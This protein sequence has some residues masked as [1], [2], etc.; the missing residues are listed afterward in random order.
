MN[1]LNP[2]G[3][4]GLFSLPIIV[5]LHL[6]RDRSRQVTVSNL[7]MWEFLDVQ[8]AGQRPRKLPRSWILYIDLL[9][10]LLLSLA[11]ARPEMDFLPLIEEK[12]HVIILLDDSTSMLAT[13]EIPTRFEAAKQRTFQE[14]NNLNEGDVISVITFGGE[15]NIVGDNRDMSVGDLA[16]RINSLHAGSEG[17]YLQDAVELAEFLKHPTLPSHILVFTDG[18][19]EES[20]IGGEILIE[21]FG[22]PV[23]NQALL[24]LDVVQVSQFKT[25]VFVRVVNF[26]EEFTTRE[27]VLIVDGKEIQNEVIGLEPLG[28]LTKT[29]SLAGTPENVEINLVGR[30][31]LLED[32]SAYFVIHQGNAVQVALVAEEPFPLDKALNASP[33]VELEIFTPEE[34]HPGLFYDLIVFRGYL[35]QVWP[36]GLVLVVDPP[37]S[38]TLLEVT[39]IIEVGENVVQEDVTALA[40]V[41]LDTVRWGGAWLV[42]N[43]KNYRKL[44][45][46]TDATLL[47]YNDQE[48]A[49]IYLLLPDLND[50]NFT[51]H[52]AFPIL[53]SNIIDEARPLNYPS[54]LNLGKELEIGGQFIHPQIPGFYEVEVIDLKGETTQVQIG[55]NAG[56]RQ[57]SNPNPQ[58][59]VNDWQI[60]QTEEGLTEFN[61][62]DITPWL[63]TLALLFLFIEVRWAWR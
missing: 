36:V 27:I 48:Y 14:L 62:V 63:L 19:L 26:S 17:A 29:W 16:D 9:I 53:I 24:D 23:N 22:G 41:G 12:Q 1:I 5:W 56:T 38:S 54:Q 47:A 25:E 58:S 32:D 28:T 39:G 52:P 37:V 34:Y 51:Q 44:A 55:V 15:V 31:D 35:P 42:E 11:W 2:L 57:E 10:A 49:Q 3:L 30:D 50:G 33:G 7:A 61:P 20:E 45:W 8:M 13:D 46:T 60:S 43:S 6:R 4:L 59:W 18:A 21:I 40:Q